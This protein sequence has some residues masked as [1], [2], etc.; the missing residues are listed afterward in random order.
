MRRATLM[1]L[2]VLVAAL[3]VAGCGD[4]KND[5][6]PT[7]AEYK[8]DYAPISKE[9]AAIGVDVGAA[10]NGASGKSDKQLSKTFGDL[11]DR[12]SKAADELDALTPPANPAIKTG[13][14]TLVKGL[15]A[16]ADTLEAISKAAEKNDLKAAGAAAAKLTGDAALIRVPRL[17]LNKALG[18][19]D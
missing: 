11:G 15:N 1:L 2:A 3:A 18:V 8:Q 7:K 6:V 9:I 5:T 17:A 13:H 4:G 10:I 16:S 14:A 12:T 19:K